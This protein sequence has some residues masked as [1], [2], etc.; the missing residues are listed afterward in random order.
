[1]AV[2]G[3]PIQGK[4]AGQL[5]EQLP[6][7]SQTAGELIE[8]AYELREA[9]RRIKGAITGEFEGEEKQDKPAP[10]SVL[11]QLA[12]IRNLVSDSQSNFNRVEQALGCRTPDTL[13]RIG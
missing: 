11:S 3:E 1:M 4:T 5:N 2:Y 10:S 8:W 13:R 7:V 6:T 12:T 9:S